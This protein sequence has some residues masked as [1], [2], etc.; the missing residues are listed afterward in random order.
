MIFQKILNDNAVYTFTEAEKA[1]VKNGDMLL[2]SF[3]VKAVDC[4]TELTVSVCGNEMTYAVPVQ[5]TRIGMPIKAEGLDRITLFTEGEIEIS[6]A[7]LENRGGASFEDLLLESGTFITDEFET[8]ELSEVG[9]GVGGTTDI[10]KHGNYVYCIGGDRLSIV[11]VKDSDTVKTVGRLSGISAR[12]LQ[13][14]DDGR[15]ALVT[16]R[17]RGVF[18]IDVSVPERPYIR[19]VYDSIE[20]AT[21]LCISGGYAFICNRQ[22]GVEVVDISDPDQPRHVTNMRVGG[23]VQSCAVREGIFYGGLW[24]EGLVKMYDVRDPVDPVFLGQAS[25][26]GKGDGLSIAKYSGKTYLYAALGHH[27]RSSLHPL[28]PLSDLRYGQGNGFDIFDVSNPKAPVWLSTSN[29][30][31]RYYFSGYDYWETEC[32]CDGEGNRYVYLVSTFNGVYVYDVNDPRAP[33]RRMHIIAPIE[34]SSENYKVLHSSVRPTVLPFDQNE[35]GRAAFG[36]V[37]VADG[38]MYAACCQTDAHLIKNDRL[39]FENK[40]KTVKSEIRP[41]QPYPCC[42]IE[43]DADRIL[44]C[45]GQ[46]YGVTECGGKL[47]IAAADKGIIFT[48]KE[49]NVISGY[50]TEGTAIWCEVSGDIIYC[51]E[52]NAGLGIYRVQ[53]TNITPLRR[54]CKGENVRHVRVSADGRYAVLQIGGSRVSVINTESGEE[55]LSFRTHALMYHHNLSPLVGG[56]YVGV[57]DNAPNEWWIDLEGEPGLI[58]DRSVSKASMS[59]GITAYKDGALEITG[60][61]GIA[62]Y[63]PDTESAADASVYGKGF[64]GKPTAYG[65]KLIACGRI[66]GKVVV[67]D[68]SDVTSPRIIKEYDVPGNPDIALC[69]DGYAYIPLGYQ[70]LVRLPVL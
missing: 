30:D 2:F 19:S 62:V 1:S 68:I 27:S 14:T 18:L 6:G 56:R 10:V 23:E 26:H 55:K 64:C 61:G 58:R 50:K 45:E 57:F 21:G 44:K 17:D 29:V 33:K 36:A 53:G 63:R 60:G 34:K 28:T 42:E 67:G 3:D 47:L 9:M 7:E 16:G 54:F 66:Y 37:A 52:K 43:R 20:M 38:V 15:T 49:L 25:L 40:E 48:D 69:C 5:K 4:C 11:D 35:R 31:G 41:S 39:F 13:L 46:I 51:A 8:L 70:G 12:Q 65:D 32:A 22:Y 24:G 59:T